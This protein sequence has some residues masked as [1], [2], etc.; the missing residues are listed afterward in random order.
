[1]ILHKVTGLEII[2]KSI[3]TIGNIVLYP[4]MEYG[5]VDVHLF[6][7][8]GARGH[9]SQGSLMCPGAA[10]RRKMAHSELL[11]ALLIQIYLMSVATYKC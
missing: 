7:S 5:Y 3:A 9:I 10:R 11:Q 2:C 4:P 8:Q 6:L 1:M